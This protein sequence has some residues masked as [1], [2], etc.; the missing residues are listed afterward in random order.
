M[1]YAR[2]SIDSPTQMPSMSTL[3]QRHDSRRPREDGSG[4][5]PDEA[6]V[7]QQQRLR[8]RSVLTDG[9]EVGWS[10]QGRYE[11]DREN[12]RRTLPSHFGL[13]TDD[14]V[15]AHPGRRPFSTSDLGTMMVMDGRGE[16]GTSRVD[17][18]RSSTGARA[19]DQWE[20][21]RDSIQQQREGHTDNDEVHLARGN[22]AELKLRIQLLLSKLPSSSLWTRRRRANRRQSR[23][24]LALDSQAS[25]P[26]I[27]SFL[28]STTPPPL[29]TEKRYPTTH[30]PYHHHHRR[31]S[32]IIPI[33]G[34][35]VKV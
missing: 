1:S 25:T 33:F 15:R 3:L 24:G 35:R 23:L 32:S 34:K 18:P 26:T 11:Q 14:A 10:S 19:L 17:R 6:V 31:L 27:H 13:S 2:D 5:L 20:P 7:A 28:P 21:Q 4:V 16:N 29:V 12:R 9:E 22:L 8:R 30:P